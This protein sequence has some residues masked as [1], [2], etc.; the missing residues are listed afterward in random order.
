[1]RLIAVLVTLCIFSGTAAALS[2]PPV[3]FFSRPTGSDLVHVA[4]L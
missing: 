4:S 2:L 3:S 1:M